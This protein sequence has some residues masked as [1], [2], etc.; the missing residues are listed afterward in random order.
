MHF[1]FPIEKINFD[2][3][4]QGNC[5]LKIYWND[6][7]VKNN[8]I[9]DSDIKDKNILKVIF[10]KND[11][12]DTN[13]FAK[14]KSFKI[15]NGDFT[16][17]FCEFDY[18]IDQTH[19]KDSRELIVNNGY[20]GYIGSMKIN[21]NQCN[22]LLKKAAWTIA[23]RNFLNPKE[24]GRGNLY[25]EK[26][27]NTVYDDARWMYTGSW[28]PNVKEMVDY[29]DQFTIKQT[30]LPVIFESFRKETETWLT[31]SNRVKLKNFD[32]FNHFCFD[33]GIL[34]F[35][36]SFLL[37]YN[38]IY[39]PP[40]I[41]QFV[42]EISENKNIIY[43]DIFGEI[44][45]N[46]TVYLEFPSPWYD[47]NKLL[48][49]IKEAKSKNCYTVVDLIWCPVAQ[50]KIDLDLDLFDEVWFS[51]N[52]TWP[53][54]HLRPAIR[55]SKKRIND[56]ST[57]INKWGY[58]PKVEANIFLNLIKKYSYDFIFEKYKEDAKSICKTFNLK[59]TEVLWF[60]KHESAQHKENNYITKHFF[61]DDFICIRKLLEHKGEYFW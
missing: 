7:E 10:T 33:K 16:A 6:Y 26:T 29:V 5:D 1:N 9:C 61:L 12:A 55:W 19:H 28:P 35:I 49:I 41:Y 30:K 43:K 34:T 45:K 11:P 60:T 40:K 13:S 50:N 20:F 47:N 31:K 52:K 8:V 27:F 18:K 4:K 48:E 44:E 38:V 58:Y 2:F 22:S 15:N 46:S 14:L 51:M 42:G 24:R 39:K 21:I 59:P 54:S 36:N 37:R 3:E 32:N 23:D 25:R 17:W 57:F 53:I 56:I